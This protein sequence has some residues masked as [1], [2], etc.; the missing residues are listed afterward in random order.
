LPATIGAALPHA[1]PVDAWLCSA[2]TA[3]ASSWLCFA[4][5]TLL[6]LAKFRAE[7]A[8]CDSRLLN[9]PRT[10]LCYVGVRSLGVRSCRLPRFVPPDCETALS[11]RAG[12][13]V[14]AD[15]NAIVISLFLP[16]CQD[17][18]YVMADTGPAGPCVSITFDEATWHP[19]P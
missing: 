6:V 11:P 9:E 10:W 7:L 19:P 4:K 14:A 5:S 12:S 1:V 18:S 13:G 17:V 16:L 3:R 2:K 15:N 8:A